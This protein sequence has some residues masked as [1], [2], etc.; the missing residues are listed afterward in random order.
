MASSSSK[1]LC[2]DM[3]ACLNTKD[4]DALSTFVADDFSMQIFPG[5]LGLPD[6]NKAQWLQATLRMSTLFPNLT[7]H[8]PEEIIIADNAVVLHMKSNGSTDAGVTYSGEYLYIFRINADGKVAS[9][10]EFVDAKAV[11]KLM[12]LG[13]GA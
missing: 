10:K 7:F 5:S 13:S 4:I 11:A 9:I 6:M 8:E 3:F 12:Q 2:L 1:Q